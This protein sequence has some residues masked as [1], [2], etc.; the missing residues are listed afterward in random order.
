LISIFQCCMFQFTEPSSGIAVQKKRYSCNVHYSLVN[1][2]SLEIKIYCILEH[3]IKTKSLFHAKYHHCRVFYLDNYDSP[4]N[5]FVMQCL[6]LVCWIETCSTGWQILKC[7]VCDTSFV[8]N[9]TQHNG[10][11]Q[12]K[13]FKNYLQQS[14]GLNSPAG[15]ARRLRSTQTRDWKSTASRGR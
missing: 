4:C 14:S 10:T 3:H 9:I 8:F 13:I 2:T 15:T 6:M 5:A 11:N 1:L 12:N 7:C